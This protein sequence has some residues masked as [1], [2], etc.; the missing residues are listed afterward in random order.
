MLKF[1]ELIDNKIPV[2]FS[3]YTD[4][5]E[6]SKNT[7]N[8]LKDVATSVG[9][10]G[11]VIKIDVEKNKQLADALR[12]KDLPTLILY[13][14]GEMVWRKSGEENANTLIALMQQHLQEEH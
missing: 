9:D 12:I 7:N 3:F 5:D 6:P 4:W 13:K 2:L 11:K 8:V 1:G 14:N 10:Q